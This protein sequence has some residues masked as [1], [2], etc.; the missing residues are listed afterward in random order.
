MV[1]IFEVK[2][3]LL[4][5]KKQ[6][7]IIPAAIILLILLPAAA[8]LDYLR[9]QDRI[10]PGVFLKDLP[11]GGKTLGGLETALDEIEIAFAGPQAGVVNIPLREIGVIP[12]AGAIFHTAYLYGRGKSWPLT[13]VER[14]NLRREGVF[15]P[16]SF[17]LDEGLF[18][19]GLKEL[20]AAFNLDPVNARFDVRYSGGE[21][22][23][24]LH[25]EQNGY[26]MDKEKLLAELQGM[27]RS[28]KP[29]F[30]VIV[31]GDI[32]PAELTVS[33]LEELGIRGLIS[34]CSTRFDPAHTDRVHNIKLAAATVHNFLLAPGQIFS[35]NGLVGD[36]TPEKGYREASVIVGNELVQGFGGGLCQVSTTL[37][38][39]ALLADLHILERHNHLMPIPYIAPGRDATIAYGVKDLKFL[40]N[41]EHYILI[42]V[43]VGPELIR[44][45]LFG[46]P[47]QEKVVIGTQ[48]L[49][50]FPPQLKYKYTPELMRG[51]EE[52]IPGSPGYLVEVWRYIYRGETRVR[53]DWISRDSYLPHAAQL[54]RGISEPKD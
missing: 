34:A 12:D 9:F 19:W 3:K 13:Y 48:I 33:H 37:Y 42:S 39:A 30:S 23:A 35:M 26:R 2:I 36:T 53:A 7:K 29:H 4:A 11:L 25:P 47:Q 5:L 18:A 10:Y 15:L 38:N 28:R 6:L 40:N 41:K 46:T 44:F 20:E 17:Y 43:D 14:L 50:V 1:G 32:V 52:L 51:E 27:L 16:L 21:T 22:R 54:R 49:A 31:P 45:S 8:G 24:A